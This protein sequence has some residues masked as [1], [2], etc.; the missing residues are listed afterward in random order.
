MTLII[1]QTAIVDPRAELG[2]DVR[3]GHFC[4]IGPHVRIGAG[5]RLENHVTITGHTSIGRDNR[6]HPGCVIGDE[7][8]DIGYRGSPTC[9]EIGDGNVFREH[10]TVHRGS[11]KEDGVTSI[12]DRGYF[13]AG[14]H[15]AHDCHI[16][17]RV[18]IANSSML[19]G[20]VH[21]QDDAVISG[22]VAVHHF[23]S[24]GK[25]SFVAGLGRVI[26]D[27]P[28][29]MLCE[30]QPARPRTI[31]MVAL[32][33]NNFSR[34]DIQLLSTAYRLLYRSKVGVQQAREQLS[35]DGGTLAPVL[36]TL[37]EFLEHQGGGRHGRGRD[38]RKAA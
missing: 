11:E 29:F 34:A 23:T 9:V 33:R 24:I 7:P 1:A 28:P 22:G 25:F 4:V 8:Q 38:R 6:F 14:A 2:D 16:G 32:K 30:G 18:V 31:N 27:V 36:A 26:T 10:V 37:F 12:G 3:I 15:I 20:H 17:N 19:G 13:M 21:V 5:T 35:G